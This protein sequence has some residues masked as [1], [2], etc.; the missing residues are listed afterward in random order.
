MTY[1][2][3]NNALSTLCKALRDH[4]DI[5]LIQKDDMAAQKVVELIEDFYKGLE[6]IANEMRDE[7][8]AKE[9]EFSS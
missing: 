3:M 5:F 4:R 8:I 7:R 9:N 2:L 1:D 6:N